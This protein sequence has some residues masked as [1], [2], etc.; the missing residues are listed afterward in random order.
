MVGFTPE[1]LTDQQIF[2]LIAFIRTATANLKPKPVYVADPDG[3]V[4][5]SEKQTFKMEVLTRDVNTPFGIAFLPDGRLLITERNGTLR[6][7]DKGKLS[8]PIKT[9]RNPTCSRMVGS[10][11]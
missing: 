8:D 10:S 1:Q 7:L 6:I 3:K 11:M 2:Q 5:T 9:P 4:I